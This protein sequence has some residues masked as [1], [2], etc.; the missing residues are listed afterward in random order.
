MKIR[1][2][3]VTNSSSS[4]F[5]A[6]SVDAVLGATL[7]ILLG[8]ESEDGEGEQNQ[9]SSVLIVK[10]IPSVKK[11][12]V[13]N[14]SP[15]T[16]Y[17]QALYKDE[18][19]VWQE[20]KTATANVEFTFTGEGDK[21]VT[22]SDTVYDNGYKAIA[23]ISE[24]PYA[25]RPRTMRPHSPANITLV[26]HTTSK[27]GNPLRRTLPFELIGEPLIQ[28]SP[29]KV[30]LLNGSDETSEFNIKVTNAENKS[31]SI[32]YKLRGNADKYI[33]VDYEKKDST[34]ALLLVKA[35]KSEP[36]TAG[37]DHNL[38][39]I[40]VSATVDDITIEDTCEAIIFC[41]GLYYMPQDHN[42]NGVKVIAASDIDSDD[43]TLPVSHFDLGLMLWDAEQKKLVYDADTLSDIEFD[44]VKS[45]S[46][47]TA[48]DNILDEA[49]LEFDKGEVIGSDNKLRR[50]TVQATYP[51][52]G[53]S[54]KA[55]DAYV[56][57]Y[58][59]TETDDFEVKI[60][61]K[62]TPDYLEESDWDKE[63]K[64]CV[65]TV[66]KYYPSEGVS[67]KLKELEQMKSQAGLKDLQE[68]RKKAWSDAYD[69]IAGEAD[70]EN[71]KAELLTAA[72]YSC[73]VARF[74]GDRAF[75]FLMSSITGPFGSYVA[76]QIKECFTDFVVACIS[77]EKK[78]M[79]FAWEYIDTRIMPTAGNTIDATVFANMD[80]LKDN[81]ASL[82][83][84]LV[85][86][87]L[88]KWAWHYFVTKKE[89]G[90]EKPIGVI[91]ALEKACGDVAGV[92]VEAIL[93]DYM[94]EMIK[95]NPKYPIYDVVKKKIQ[96]SKLIKGAKKAVS[97][98]V[99]D[100]EMIKEL[101]RTIINVCINK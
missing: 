49:L 99:S 14:T 35:L 83:K 15:I 82:A 58:L 20:D 26:V 12:E 93:G 57:A 84:W 79:D 87:L 67:Q 52:P 59:T 86:M 30:S 71:R 7:G 33:T 34:S 73:E 69:A 54:K 101:Q 38:A 2:G 41:E 66:T 4:N 1:T 53:K 90:T 42:S 22:K 76:S 36:D 5:G 13:G 88:Y 80:K 39:V 17:A 56:M 37:Y 40:E 3:F 64:N 78:G 92:G 16:I 65:Y 98:L 46:G 60:P 85:G 70:R 62:I 18:M 21:W 19:N 44:N 23:F 94:K 96:D 89:E 10:V 29:L 68:F 43:D 100:E 51:V 45:E 75:N 6:S 50:F 48:L 11:L 91:G 9:P 55:I 97:D 95:I 61:L 31:V 63:Y 81:K 28:I 25:D 72:I 24:T 47:D 74:M 77:S 27:D 8:D 32:D